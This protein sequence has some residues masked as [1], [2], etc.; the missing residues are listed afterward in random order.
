MYEGL[1]EHTNCHLSE[2]SRHIR[3]VGGVFQLRWNLHVVLGDMLSSASVHKPNISNDC[4]MQENYVDPSSGRHKTCWPLAVAMGET[5][6]TK[7]PIV[8]GEGMGR[9]CGA[10]GSRNCGWTQ[11][12]KLQWFSSGLLDPDGPGTNTCRLMPYQQGKRI[13]IKECRFIL[14]V[15]S[16]THTIRIC[17]FS[18]G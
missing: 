5:I 3:T 12:W 7:G 2:P 11:K 1:A 8:G 15:V 14:L 10:R 13:W 17:F 9:W 16:L 4:S 6:G 18:V